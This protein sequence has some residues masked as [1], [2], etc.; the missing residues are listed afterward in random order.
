MIDKVL[1][2]YDGSDESKDAVAFGAALA[3]ACGANV[4]LA[5]A[6]P[7]E[8]ELDPLLWVSLEDRAEAMLGPVKNRLGQLCAETRGVLGAPAEGLARTANELEADVIVV[9]STH[10]G[11]LGR[12]LLGSTA[13]RL[14]HCASVPVVVTPRG[15]RLEETAEV[16]SILVA[17]DGSPEARAA[18]SLADG[19]AAATAARVVDMRITGEGDPA[20]GLIAAAD[21]VDLML[22]GSRGYGRMLSTLLGSVSSHMIRAM[23]CPL[24]IVPTKAAGGA[25]EEREAQRTSS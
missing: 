16:R 23:P 15:R 11:Q 13:A 12:I 6:F 21:G 1:I 3:R 7:V 8:P 5:A 9:G 19:I 17:D 4:A 10:R 14:V 25:H 18:A 20:L 22:L 24:L 2:G